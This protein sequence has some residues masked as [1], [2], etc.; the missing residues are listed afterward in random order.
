VKRC[1]DVR[2]EKGISSVKKEESGKRRK[3]VYGTERRDGYRCGIKISL[4]V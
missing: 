1:E 4:W 2:G 3:D